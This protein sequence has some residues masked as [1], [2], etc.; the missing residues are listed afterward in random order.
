MGSEILQGF[1]AEKGFLGFFLLGGRVQWDEPLEIVEL[2]TKL[3]PSFRFA[4]L[5]SLKGSLGLVGSAIA[6]VQPDLEFYDLVL[7]WLL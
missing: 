5:E 4:I 3:T 2:S 6:G 7:R 1:A